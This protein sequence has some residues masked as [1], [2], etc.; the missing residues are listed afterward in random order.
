[1]K[2]SLITVTHNS[3]VYL[4]ECIKSVLDQ[5]SANIEHI[6]VDGGSTDGTLD[7][8]KKYDRHIAKW[9]TEK[10][11]GMYDA[12]NKGISMA[13]GDILGILNSD[14]IFASS[15]VIGAIV[16]CFNEHKVDA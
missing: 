4:E 7:I 5:R 14:D 12:I 16:D 11:R 9:K 13:T 6:I 3:A 10:D 2:V 15:D 1:M 8:I